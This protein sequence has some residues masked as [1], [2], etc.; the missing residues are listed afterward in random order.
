MADSDVPATKFTSVQLPAALHK[1]I[2]E[3]SKATGVTMKH[4]ISQACRDR[5]AILKA[6]TS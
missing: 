1:A 2:R 6:S 5:M 3:Q 4:F